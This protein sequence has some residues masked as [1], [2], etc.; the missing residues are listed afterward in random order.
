MALHTPLYDRHVAAGARMVDFAGYDMPLQYTGIRE[1]HVAVR[2]RAG[3][4]DVSHMGEVMVDG[5]GAVAWVQHLVTNDI[6][7]AEAGQATYT[8]MCNDD[9]GIIDDLIVV[10]VDDNRLL[11]VVNAATRHKDVAWMRDHL[12][13]GVDLRDASDELSLLAVQGPRAVEILTPITAMNG[14]GSLA[15]LPG[16]RSA[17]VHVHGID[18][19]AAQRVT[20]TGYTGEDGFEIYIENGAA[21]ALWDILMDAGRP[22][23]L[24]PAGLGARDT[25]RLEAG[26]RLY[27][28]DMDDST[29]PYSVGL[30]WT[31]K[32]DKGD[33]IGAA[34][35]RD[36]KASP[37]RRF[38]GLRLGP[39]TIARHGQAVLQDG[40]EVG[41]VTS[42]T[43]GFT[44]GA[45]VATA[46]VVPGFKR[47]GDVS[48]DIRGIV[49]PA[50]VVALP[51]YKRPKGD[52]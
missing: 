13:D 30:G 1:E 10:R 46:S 43:M 8:V 48:V 11:I 4:F 52:G 36:L 9:G 33:F 20:R 49:A 32:L 7:R 27:G 37:P 2:E 41:E 19:V 42:G 35:L 50:E 14:G 51:F 22:H 25:L 40:R 29:D 39:R 5:P 28:Q 44:V 12:A 26:L 3:L 31:V 16:F 6:G 17:E 38:V 45:P 18:T 15:D 21:P 47:D 24:V 34:A 23:G